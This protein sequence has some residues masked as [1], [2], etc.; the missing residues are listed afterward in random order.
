MTYAH[1]LPSL[2]SDGKLSENV[3]AEISCK[4]EQSQ[5]RL[6]LCRAQPILEELKA[7]HHL[8]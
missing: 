6:E 5:A 1:N 4:Q 7:R 8:A 3:R 2:E